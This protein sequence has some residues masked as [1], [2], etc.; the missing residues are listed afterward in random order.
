VSI[1]FAFGIPVLLFVVLSGITL[2]RAL[3]TRHRLADATA[4]GARAAAVAGETNTDVVHD[5]VV[6][7]F[8]DEANRCTS[9]NVVTQVIPGAGPD[10]QALQV[11]ATC[12]L[13]PM[14][15]SEAL[16]VMTPSEITVVAA[17]P[18]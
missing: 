9:L 12:M 5:L 7:Q 17:M 13:V 2:G 16:S 11:T 18:L 10:T 15:N 1:E 14:F 3:L 6:Q 4:F 8:S